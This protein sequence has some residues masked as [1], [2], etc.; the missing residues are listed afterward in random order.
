M[1][2][3]FSESD[4]EEIMAGHPEIIEDGLTLLGRQVSLGHLR[5]D[6]LFKD[7]FGDTLVVELKRGNI[8]RGHVGQIIEYSGFA[9]KQIFP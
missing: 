7:K 9:Q 1:S 8:K 5:A 2:L 3:E 4:M 6:L